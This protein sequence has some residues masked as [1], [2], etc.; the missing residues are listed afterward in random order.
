MHS[1]SVLPDFLIDAANLSEKNKLTRSNEELVTK[2]KSKANKPNLNVEESKVDDFSDILFDLTP[3]DYP[4]LRHLP[5]AYYRDPL[6]QNDEYKALCIKEPLDGSDIN[7]LLVLMEGNGQFDDLILSSGD[8]VYR[9]AKKDLI[10]LFNQQL[11]SNELEEMIRYMYPHGQNIINKVLSPGK[12]HD[13]AY[14]FLSEEAVLEGEKRKRY[15]Y[16]INISSYLENSGRTGLC[17]IMRRLT[18]IPL[19]LEQLGV[20][21]FIIANCTP[22]SG[23]VII[24]GETGSGKSTLCAAI[25]AKIRQ[26]TQTSRF[27]LTYEAPI[28]YILTEIDGPNPIKQHSVGEFGHFTTFYDGLRNALRRTPEV[29]YLG[30]SRDRETFMTLPKIAESGHMGL[31][32]THANSIAA[33]FSRIANEVGGDADGV[34]RSLVV[35]SH[36]FVVQYLARNGNEVVPVQEVLLFTN[37]VKSKILNAEGNILN[38]IR[39]VVEEHGQTMLA[40][41]QELLASGKITKATF[42]HI[43]DNQEVSA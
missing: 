1:Q 9:K 21:P 19:T 36:L 29:I 4:H 12:D 11:T 17:L 26:D 25:A 18:T 3:Q 33:I 31:T 13:D 5:P 24:A 34:I 35:S 23:L 28:E 30:E 14:D 7:K 37:E 42:N 32:T 20:D 8:F 39:N 27:M 16:R 40:H 15:R 38:V 22:R 2:E 43:A 6:I 41:A 10:K